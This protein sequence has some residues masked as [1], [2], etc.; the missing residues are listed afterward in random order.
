MFVLAPPLRG[1]GG[2]FIIVLNNI[3]FP[4]LLCQGYKKCAPL[5]HCSVRL[6]RRSE[7]GGGA[8]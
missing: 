2:I 4:A 1:Q 7:F 5:T 6:L 3:T 8:F